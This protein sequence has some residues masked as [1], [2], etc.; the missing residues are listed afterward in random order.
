MEREL[1]RTVYCLVQE[2]GRSRGSA[3]VVHPDW[4]IVV[5]HLWAA[6][7]NRPISWAC[8]RRHWPPAARTLEL[9]S[10][11][12]MSRRQRRAAVR[13]LADAVES[14]LRRRLAG[15]EP[16]AYVDA[17]P[18]PIGPCSKDPDAASGFAGCGT[19]RGYKLHM[20][21]DSRRIPIVW[22][23]HPMNV[24]EAKAAP[25]L[26]RRLPSVADGLLA[27]DT[28]YDANALYDEAGTRG[29]QLYASKRKGKD[30]GHRQHSPWRLIAHTDK[31]DAWRA[32]LTKK[33]RDVERCFA[34]LTGG[35][36]GLSPLPSWVRGLRRVTQW[37]QAKIIIHLAKRIL[38]EA[39]TAM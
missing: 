28:A 8:Q 36:M 24:N 2:L 12:T 25:M 19:G 39:Q 4:K 16:L 7:H 18:L 10:E 11:S 15:T 1:F 30:L 5:V 9:P 29:W 27:G 3:G 34:H 32:A 26:I 38:R 6:L 22:A 37:V 35:W 31:S 20:I 14:S 21:S 33:R 13:S 17:K 23:V